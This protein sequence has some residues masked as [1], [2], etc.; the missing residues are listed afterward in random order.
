[1]DDNLSFYNNFQ[2]VRKSF[3]SLSTFSLNHYGLN[4]FLQAYIFKTFCISKFLYGIEIMSLNKTTIAKINTYQNILIKSML[5]ISK[6]C[7]TSELLKVLRLY[8]INSLVV[9]T[10][11]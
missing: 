1:M 8:D 3:Y 5:G 4:P 10:K 7:H 9:F 2:S 6:Y 11:L